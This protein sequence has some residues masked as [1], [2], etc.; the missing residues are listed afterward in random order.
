MDEITKQLSSFASGFTAEMMGPT[1]IAAARERLIDTIACAAAAYNS[2]TTRA[3]M[4]FAYANPP[5]GHE[6]AVLFHGTR[7]GLDV[8]AFA[9][10]C[11]IR[12]LD[13]NDRYPGGHPSDC[14]GALLALATARNTSGMRLLQ[15]MAV[16][17]EVFARLSDGA[18][19]S[20]RGWDQ[21]FVVGLS[22]VS[23]LI[24]L[25]GLSETIAANAIGMFASTG[26]PLRIT[27]AGELTEW[28]NVATPYAVRNASF[29]TL[30]A[31]HEMQG[32]SEAFS[33]RNGLF[34]NITGAFTL[35]PFPGFG[36]DPITPRV[37]LKCW[38]VETNGQPVVWAALELKEKVTLNELAAIEVFTNEFT[39]YE[40][41]SEPQKWDPQT[42]ETAD[43]SLPYIFART[44]MY[45]PLDEAAF[46][47]GAVRD[48]LLRP[49]MKMIKVSVDQRIND[50]PAG[51][52]E[53]L[54]L[55]T[56]KNGKQVEAVIG[57]PLGHP[58]NPMSEAAISDKFRR[59]VTPSLGSERTEAALAALWKIDQVSAVGPVMESLHVV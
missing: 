24:N 16:T 52:V 49:L 30:L 29:L 20:R 56:L 6:G 58:D 40:I 13:F 39:V 33:G 41:G 19:L 48:P 2:E 17:Y 45:G 54:A 21:G 31:S 37:Q 26:V 53:M 9:N 42:R 27:R 55:A 14:L 4:R 22:T 57:N 11:M 51:Q 12:A 18:M 28:K 25:L 36:G 3:A 8:A 15:A 5:A 43:H 1:L 10:A 32:P 35:A 47:V 59:L 44:F 38:P 23:G 50:L 46:Q 34:E 7:T